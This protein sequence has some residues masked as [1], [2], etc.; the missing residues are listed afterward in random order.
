MDLKAKEADWLLLFRKKILNWKKLGSTSEQDQQGMRLCRTSKVLMW[1]PA[2][3]KRILVRMLWAQIGSM[4]RELP[5]HKMPSL[6]LLRS[7]LLLDTA[8]ICVVS[9]MFCLKESFCYNMMDHLL[10]SLFSVLNNLEITD[11]TAL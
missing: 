5:Q 7:Q 10:L 11:V 6:V 1:L 4:G 2:K 3:R 9:I 8:F